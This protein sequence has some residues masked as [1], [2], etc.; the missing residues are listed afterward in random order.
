M[1][2]LNIELDLHPEWRSTCLDAPDTCTWDDYERADQK[3]SILYGAPVD[4][5]DAWWQ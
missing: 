3:T 1:Q 4:G 2:S 5:L